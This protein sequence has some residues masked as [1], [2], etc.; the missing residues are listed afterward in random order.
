MKEEKKQFNL[1]ILILFL[2][3]IFMGAMDNGIVSPAREIIQNGFSVEQNLGI[4][5]ITIY[6]LAY[7]ISM[8]IVSKLSDKFGYKKIY[9]FGIATFGIGSL[10]CALTSFTDNFTLFLI[11]RVIQA[12][13]AGG[14]I[15]IATNVIGQSFPKE[16]EGMALG[17]VGA[18]YGIATILG[19]TIG[20][21]ILN[22]AGNEHWLWLFIIN[23]PISLIIV[24][25]SFKIPKLHINNEYKKVDFLGG[26]IFSVVIGS[27]MY[28]LTNLDFFNFFESIK[29]IDVYPYLIS[30][31][32]F[33]PILVLV[34]NKVQDP[35]ISIKY[36]K[37]VRMLLIFLLAFVVG[38]GM[39]GMIFIP[40]FAENILKLKTGT[41][42]YIVTI[43]AVF[44]GIAAPLSGSLID[45]KGPKFV[46]I[47]GFLFTIIGTLIMALLVTH[48]LNFITLIIGLLFMGLGIGFTIGAPLNY[49]TLRSVPKEEG[50]TALATMSLMRSIGVTISPSIMIGF[51]VNATKNLQGNL[52][53]AISLPKGIDLATISNNT[54]IDAFSKLTSSDVTTIT[55]NLKDIISEVVPV[56]VKQNVLDIIEN[57]RNAIANAFQSTL[58]AGYTNIYI[59]SAIIALVGLI[60][61]LI[62]KDK[63]E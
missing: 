9:V 26:V 32:I 46:M 13:G 15:P 51:I 23:V 10:F 6:T 44:S 54:S 21:F 8:P 3:G 14:I 24:A 22:L 28:A 45:K 50:A 4:W 47:M 34:E 12:I 55:D 25:L 48:Y 63:N 31:I 37:N 27:L 17:L 53:N 5:M 61:S 35:I 62:L 33:L 20:S 60:I 19:P 43:L 1:V 18:M 49:L 58:N 40:Q 52:T 36:F 11:A 38:I 16:K 42:G 41:G 7:A 59:A 2:L 39:M 30:F 56:F 29:S 57:S